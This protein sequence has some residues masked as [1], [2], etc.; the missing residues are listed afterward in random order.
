MKVVVT[1]GAGFVGSHV[2]ERFA[3]AGHAIVALDSFARA[4]VL[5]QHFL[6]KV[7]SRYNWN[8]L[9]NIPSVELIEGDVRDERTVDKVTR[10]A[11]VIVHTAAQ[12]AVTTSVLDPR[13]D[14]ETNV[15][16]TENILEGARKSG[17]DPVI[18]FS[19]TNKVYGDRVNR[20]PIGLSNDRYTFDDPR[21]YQGVPET[22]GID[23]CHHTPYG[24]SKLAADLLVQEYARSYGLRTAV[25]RM[26]CIYGPRQ[27]GNEDQGW[28]AHFVLS[29]LTS[30]PIT[31][32]GD[33]KQVRDV[34]FVDDLVDAYEAY[35][36][37]SRQLGGRVFNIG[38]G[39]EF[40]LSLLELVALLEGL[41]HRKLVLSFSGWR[42]ADQRVYV[43]DNHRL[44]SDLGWTPKV[45]P[46]DGVHRM[47][48]WASSEGFAN[49]HQ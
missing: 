40:T 7:V 44:H 27:F 22:L 37:H 13:T 48:E 4:T 8:R 10:E 12:V 3:R 19:S 38:G 29:G 25:F 5:G 46:K 32:Y 39:P 9:A 1:G 49:L 11:D 2:A 36:S 30:R 17:S 18:I 42:P 47:V 6:G 23:E 33:G 16:G 26:S 45:A 20:I 34:L 14:F 41:L 31:I 43:S 28:L 24:A 15:I 35:V 21:F